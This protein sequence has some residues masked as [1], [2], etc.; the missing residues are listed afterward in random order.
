MRRTKIICTIGP[1]SASPLILKK[2]VSVGMDVARFNM[3]HGTQASHRQ[4]MKDVRAAAKAVKRPVALLVDLQ[5]PKIRLGILPE[6][7][8]VFKKGDVLVFGKGKGAIPVTYEG[9]SRDV[10]IGDRILI[11]D[12][13]YEFQIQSIRGQQIVASVMTAGVLFSHKGMNFPDTKLKIGVVTE[14]DKKDLAFALKQ[15]VDFVAMSFVTSASQVRALRS[16]ISHILST[17]RPK[18]IVKIEKHEAIKNFNAILKAS[19]GILV[20][21]GD[22]GVEMPAEQVPVLQEEI[23]EK[24][25]HAKK[26]VI[27]ATQMLDSMIRNPLPTR[28]EVSDVAHAVMDRADMVMLSGET[29]I[30]KYPVQAVEMMRKIIEETEASPYD[31]V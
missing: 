22:L 11:D 29:A 4:M 23:I 5:G 25:R 1:A 6:K 28:A 9:L 30:G 2:I 17:Y 31:D 26:P 8:V 10:K 13:V 15:R 20:A 16:T 27:V 12:G 21:R 14:K 3:S 24:C 18:L 7:G 19:D